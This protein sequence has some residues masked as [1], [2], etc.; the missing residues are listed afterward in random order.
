MK[1]APA[2]GRSTVVV[3]TGVP[4]AGKSTLAEALAAA[5]AVPI[6][7]LDA[8]KERLYASGGM[9]QDRSRLRLAAE[10]EL[11]A[12]VDV[13]AG[14]VVMDIWV[15]PARDTE[16]VTGLL[17]RLGRPVVEVLCRV[18]P[19]VAAARYERRARAVGPH[20]PPDAATLQRIR[21]AVEVIEPLGVGDCVE[22]DTSRPVEISELLRQLHVCEMTAPL[23]EE[24]S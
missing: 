16:R 15:A 10:T 24:P 20:L 7:S 19:A 11:F 8:I 22:V 1:V 12:R 17:Q 23:H 21:D 14:C 18:P 2:D 3:V 5:L 9:S 13:T 4:G 6:L